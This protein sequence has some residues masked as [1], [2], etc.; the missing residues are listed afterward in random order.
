MS[1]IKKALNHAYQ[2]RDWK[3]IKNISE[4]TTISYYENY[5]FLGSEY[6]NDWKKE[7]DD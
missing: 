7:E 4:S 6:T 2:K 1:V 3:L 5:S